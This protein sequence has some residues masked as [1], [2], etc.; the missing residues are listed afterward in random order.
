M[1]ALLASPASN[2]FII[3]HAARNLAQILQIN[4]YNAQA[5][6]I[7]EMYVSSWCYYNAKLWGHVELCST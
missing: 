6:D 5:L 2:D 1:E 4:G 7:I 3:G